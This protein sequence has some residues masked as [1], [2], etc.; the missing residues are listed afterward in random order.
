MGSAPAAA[1]ACP[2]GSPRTTRRSPG[3][4]SPCPTASARSCGSRSP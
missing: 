1:G 4:G 3:S 2:V